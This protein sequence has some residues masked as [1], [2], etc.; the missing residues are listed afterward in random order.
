M[1][2]IFFEIRDNNNIN[3]IIYK[4]SLKN[5][6]NELL[7]RVIKIQ[8]NSEKYFENSFNLSEIQK[9]RYFIIYDNIDECMY[10]ILSGVKTNNSKIIEEN[11]KLK[12]TIPLINK[13]YQSIS[14]LINKKFKNQI[15]QSQNTLI[16]K[17]EKEII[18]LKSEINILKSEKEKYLRNNYIT[19]NVEINNIT[20]KKF[21]VRLN[22][23][24]YFVFELVKNEFNINNYS[25]C[26]VIYNGFTLDDYNKTLEDYKIINNSTINLNF[27]NIGGQY[28]IKT[29]SGKTIILELEKNETIFNVK[30]K[31]NEKE[32]I[33]LDQLILICAGKRLEDNKTILDY[34]IKSESTI[35]ISFS[36]R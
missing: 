23:S 32:G 22:D 13:K 21:I 35:L 30:K 4:I 11:D 6:S 10:D 8:N 36:L 15:I 7:I 29:L 20:N 26:E 28:F 1:N 34:K 24:I 18:L 2:P 16:E 31:I 27:F 33:P 17:L 25:F 14:F 12:L 19:I 3:E 5:L 9:V